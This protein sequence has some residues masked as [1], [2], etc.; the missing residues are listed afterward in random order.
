MKVSEFFNQQFTKAGVPIDMNVEANKAFMDAAAA[1]TVEIPDDIAKGVDNKF[2]TVEAAKNNHPEIKNYYQTQALDT[3]DKTTIAALKELG[4]PQDTIDNLVKE[5]GSTFKRV[6]LMFKKLQ[7]LE[8]AKANASKPDQ[9]IYQKQIDDL[10][11]QVRAEKDIAVKTIA[12]KNA[13]EKSMRLKYKYG[14]MFNS[15]KTIYD[16]LDPEDKFGTLEVI[17]ER[18]LH[19]NN[20]K[21]DLNENGGVIL[22]KND[23]TTYFGENNVPVNA[24]Q[25]V[26]Q[27]LSRKKLLVSAIP[28][29]VPGTS[30]AGNA[31]NGSNNAPASGNGGNGGGAKVSPL[32]SEHLKTSLAELA[33]G[34]KAMGGS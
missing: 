3:I 26:D 27:L 15:V 20:A 28:P 17:L 33:S 13:F 5:E 34:S 19:D 4:V 30:T 21:M 9:A 1:M 31:N 16:T 10:Q 23:G 32:Y 2:I 25:F 22:L 18:A 7:D 11:A 8:K 6:P 29:V 14:S 24:Q 12:D